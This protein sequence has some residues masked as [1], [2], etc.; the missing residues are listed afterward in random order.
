MGFRVHMMWHSDRSPPVFR[1]FH[2]RIRRFCSFSAV[3]ILVLTLTVASALQAQTQAEKT[4]AT[5]TF[6]V[7]GDSRNCGDIVMPAIA[8]GVKRSGAEFYWHLGDYRAIYM[9]DEDYLAAHPKTYV[10]DYETNAWPDFLQH[11]IV[12]FGDLPVFLGIGNHELIP[13]KGRPDYIA[14]FA[15]WLDK[16]VLQKQRLAD[17]PADHQLKSFYH[18]IE[19][20]IDFVNL[21]NASPDE[22]D[23]TQLAWFK[24]VLNRDAANH[25]IRTVVLG[26]HAALPDSLSAGHG[27]N[28]SAQ[29][30]VSG[31]QAYAALVSFRKQTHKN[32]Y[33][34]AS[35]SHFVMDNIYADACHTGDDVLPG[36]IIGTAGAV[37]YQ[38]PVEHASATIARTGVYGYL[39]ATVSEDGSIKF[40]FQQVMQSDVPAATVNEFTPAQVKWCFEQN[41]S[42]S[43]IAG[44]TCPVCKQ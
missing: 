9:I 37:H 3:A 34:L 16:P 6:A 10:L 27:M 2:M 4:H 32:V 19:R 43:P 41:N 18:W 30:T 44:P 28:D 5:W 8:A 14:Q 15:D 26:M 1:E 42:P 35:H 22:F 21:D 17:N 36:W 11:Q 38:L 20:G 24:N 12:P 25:E 39:L 29:Q 33:V 31:R 13:P 40:D 23:A 7:S